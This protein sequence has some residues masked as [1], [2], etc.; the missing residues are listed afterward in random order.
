MKRRAFTTDDISDVESGIPCGKIQLINL[1]A[2][3]NVLLGECNNIICQDA[4]KFVLKN[5]PIF[6]AEKIKLMRLD[7][8]KTKLVDIGLHKIYSIE[9]IAI[10]NKSRLNENTFSKEWNENAKKINEL[11]DTCID[12]NNRYHMAHT[13]ISS[14]NT[15]HRLKTNRCTYILC[16]L[17]LVM[18]VMYYY[19]NNLF[20]V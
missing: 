9:H 12:H 3:Q 18:I 4:T 17:V 11:V 15:T 1:L 6:D 5:K 13:I 14:K 7:T 20:F 10:D 19:R 2:K 8:I 16:A